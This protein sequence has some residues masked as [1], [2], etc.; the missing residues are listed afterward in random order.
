MSR[1]ALRLLRRAYTGGGREGKGR[2][3]ERARERRR[4]A[5]CGVKALM[6]VCLAS[7][8]E[9]SEGAGERERVMRS[10]SARDRERGVVNVGAARASQ[11]RE[12][13]WWF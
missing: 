9:R 8:R 6:Y 5:G 2:G 1:A 4:R 3:D 11:R 10:E 7:F 12:V 13:R